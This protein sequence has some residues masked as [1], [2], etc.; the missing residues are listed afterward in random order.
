MK[1]DID[2]E[3]FFLMV[4]R[5]LLECLW[6]SLR[7]KKKQPVNLTKLEKKIERR[8]RLLRVEDAWHEDK[9]R[10]EENENE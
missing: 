6:N 8:R 2:L 4:W 10:E 5:T 9:V 3:I 7:M 1:K